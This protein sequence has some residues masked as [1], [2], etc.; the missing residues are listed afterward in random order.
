MKKIS[1]TVVCGMILLMMFVLIGP[2]Q[3]GK[4]GS[5][6]T[7]ISIAAGTPGAIF[8]TLGAGM[9]KVINSENPD[10]NVIVEQTGG[11]RENTALLLNKKVE[12]GF[13][14]DD[15]ALKSY[16]P[17][18]YVYGWLNYI[19]D[20]EIVTL[21]GTKIDGIKDL[22]GRKVSLGPS[23]SAANVLVRE[24]LKAYGIGEKEFEAQFLEWEKASDAMGDGLLAAASYMGAWPMSAVQSLAARKQIKILTVDPEIIKKNFKLPIRP[25]V[26]P[27]GAYA[28]L[29]KE[30]PTIGVSTSVWIRADLAEETVYRIAK[31][32]LTNVDYI[33]KVHRV[34]KELRVMSKKEADDLGVKVH[35]GVIRFARETG[36]W[37]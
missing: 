2:V 26:V 31:S 27:A 29:G 17:Q 36:K 16:N 15:V 11:A 20:V 33:S 10:L 22:K 37:E 24:V 25:V 23:G 6:Q 9:S 19:T 13:C 8:Y 35:P 34:G 3:E 4:A 18:F 1:G 5:P 30:V 21:D 12:M 28:G 14:S 7:Q 32:V